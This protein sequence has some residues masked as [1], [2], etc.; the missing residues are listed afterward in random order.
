MMKE[1]NLRHLKRYS[2]QMLF[3]G[4]GPE[5]QER[6]SMSRVTLIGCGG[7]GSVIATSLVRAGVGKIKIVDRDF[8]EEEN[9][10]H[11]I[12]YDE[13][14][15]REHLPK[16]TAARR[17]LLRMNSSAS[18]EAVVT[19]VHYGNIEEIVAGSHVVMDGTDNFETRYLMNDACVKGN[20][21]WI[22]GAVAGSRGMC[23]TI[24]PGVTPCLRC[25]FPQ[26]PPPEHLHTCD[27]SGVLLSI[28]Q[29]VGSLQV[30]ECF[31]LLTG[32]Q[33][34]SGELIYCDVWEGTCVGTKLQRQE[35]CA[36]CQKEEYPA[37]KA[38]EGASVTALC[39]R[40]TV[41][42]TYYE[43]KGIH[44]ET[45]AKKLEPAGRTE[46]SPDMI[47]FHVDTYHLVIF[48]DGRVIVKGTEDPNVARAL[49]SKYIGN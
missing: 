24:V 22:Y 48:P 30:S 4:I 42:I 6:L 47:M 5:G 23:T 9:L 17:K 19:D 46:V 18:L 10:L 32:R 29:T 7:L 44:L 33:T 38:R 41:M 25:I 21:P 12:L 13:E 37:L 16:A 11:Q 2:R 36:S 39:G 26:I 43:P 45:L 49:Y 15:A 28:V 8:V 20:I 34:P 3:S 35:D 31:K 27:T 1:K 40:N 14:D